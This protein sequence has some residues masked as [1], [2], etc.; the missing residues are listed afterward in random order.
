MVTPQKAAKRRLSSAKATKTVV[1]HST[2]VK[3]GNNEACRGRKLRF[4]RLKNARI[5]HD[6]AVFL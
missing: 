5:R 6:A 2:A 4:N 1:L 3:G